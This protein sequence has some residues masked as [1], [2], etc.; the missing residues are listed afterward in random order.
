M[1]FGGVGP[2]V[3]PTAVDGART[4]V[5]WHRST[6]GW[7]RPDLAKQLNGEMAQRVFLAG[8]YL[9]E[10]DSGWGWAAQLPDVGMVEAELLGV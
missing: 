7:A 8:S 10:K 9:R 2:T 3:C 5:F 4:S 6:D 1:G